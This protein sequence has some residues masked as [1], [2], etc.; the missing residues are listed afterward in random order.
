VIISNIGGQKKMK[1][2]QFDEYCLD[3]FS[4]KRGEGGG[5]GGITTSTWE[6]IPI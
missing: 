3:I 2:A 6:T 5:R 4:M 1:R